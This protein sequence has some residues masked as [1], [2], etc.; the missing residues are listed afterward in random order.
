[1]IIRL[2]NKIRL[3]N[4]IRLINKIRLN[5]NNVHPP[6]GAAGV[7]EGEV[8][9]PQA[10]QPPQHPQG[11]LQGVAPLNPRQGRHQPPLERVLDVWG[12]MF[13]MTN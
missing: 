11:V 10:M 9:R 2:N 7:C 13:L 3:N 1:M 6:R 4:E 12:G 8:A 5:N